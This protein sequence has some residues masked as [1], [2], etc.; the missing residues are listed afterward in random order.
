MVSNGPRPP[1]RPW[2]SPGFLAVL[3]LIAFSLCLAFGW[4]DD[5]MRFVNLMTDWL[6]VR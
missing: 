6:R 5:L 3:W 1:Y 4:F 2:T